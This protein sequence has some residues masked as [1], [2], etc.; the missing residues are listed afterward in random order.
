MIQV[1]YITVGDKCFW[2]GERKGAY[3]LHHNMKDV[4]GGGGYAWPD[5]YDP[6]KAERE[7]DQ[8]NQTTYRNDHGTDSAVVVGVA[9]PP[10]VDTIGL[11]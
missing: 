4:S 5:D 3:I 9:P 8:S 7:S 2:A 11:M 1:Q 6:F 10:V